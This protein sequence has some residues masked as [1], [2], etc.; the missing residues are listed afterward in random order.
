MSQLVE[1]YLLHNL[2]KFNEIAEKRPLHDE[3]TSRRARE[4]YE[5]AFVLQPEAAL[6]ENLAVFDF[7]SYWPS[8]IVTFNLS[9]STLLD[10]KEKQALEVDIGKKSLFFQARRIFSF[11]IKRNYRHPIFNLFFP[12]KYYSWYFF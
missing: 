11:N 5:G 2:E 3:I 1:N 7:T 10:K 12:V 9:L 6:Y 4:K 8:I